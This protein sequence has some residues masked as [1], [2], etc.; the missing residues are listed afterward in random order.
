[1][2]RVSLNV[3]EVT[4]YSVRYSDYVPPEVCRVLFTVTSNLENVD[5]DWFAVAVFWPRWE[6]YDEESNKIM[7]VSGQDSDQFYHGIV[8]S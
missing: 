5:M 6:L 4:V 1:M 3:W 7:P 2:T 8:I